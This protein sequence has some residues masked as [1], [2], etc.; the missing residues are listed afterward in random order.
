MLVLLSEKRS[1]EHAPKGLVSSSLR[2]I[3]IPMDTVITTQV[4]K[5]LIMVYVG[6]PS[7]VEESIS[8]A[9]VNDSFVTEEVF[10]VRWFGRQMPTWIKGS[11]PIQR[12]KQMPIRKWERI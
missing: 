6:S 1:N 11:L 4:L 3:A 8:V 10:T 12:L 7:T 5:T 9:S 2:V